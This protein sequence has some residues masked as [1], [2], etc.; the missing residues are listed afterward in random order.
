MDP[1]MAQ[2]IRVSKRVTQATGLLELDLA[3]KALERLEQLGPLGP[4]EAQVELLRG[5]A[6]RRQHRFPEAAR[7]FH[8]A[9]RR[10][11]SMDDREVLFA[12]SLCFREAGDAN[13]SIDLLAKARGA[14]QTGVK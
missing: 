2:L 5:E 10:F 12:L 8:L 13:Q 11:S 6:F 3:D 4:L 9:A 7:A 14:N 1:R